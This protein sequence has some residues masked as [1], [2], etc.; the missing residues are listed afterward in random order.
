LKI[1]DCR[2]P[3]EDARDAGASRRHFA[4]GNLP[5]AVCHSFFLVCLLLSP[6][7]HAEETKRPIFTLHTAAGASVTGPI[8][9]IGNDWSITLGGA[10]D[11]EIKGMSL[12]ALRRSKS[13][14]P[15]FPVVEH[16]RLVNGDCLPGGILKIDGE[17]LHFRAQ[18]QSQSF[19]DQGEVL[20]LPLSAVSVLWFATSDGTAD[21]EMLR[22]RLMSERRRKDVVRLRNGDVM[23]GTISA[24]D[25]KM[26]RLETERGGKTGPADTPVERDRLAV[27]ALNTELAHAPKLKGMGARLVL[28]NGCRLTLQSAS[29]EDTRT[30]LGRTP[31]GMAVRI[32]IDQ[33]VSLDVREGQ[34]VYLS[35]LKPSRYEHTSY[36][37]V[38][39]PYVMDGSVAGRDLRLVGSTYDKGIGMHS[40]SRLSFDL[41]GGY[42]RFEALVGLDEKTG[43]QGHVLIQVLVDGKAQDLGVA[44]ELTGMDE[45]RTVQVN[46]T[47]AREVTLVVDFGHGGDVQDH[48]NWVEARLIRER[49]E[50]GR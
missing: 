5:F 10:Q 42:R 8:E 45:P 37:G 40:Q 14:L 16:V 24:L 34:A 29:T 28:S 4:I 17:R 2:L 33:I 9:R 48:V 15:T 46:L 3:I 38:S 11:K 44:N 43:R 30:I 18:F 25:E 47:G 21:A 35:D 36:F 13:L 26:L 20:I 7:L 27:V 50:D 12:I 23:E 22:R 32:P 41:G 49:I 6:S 31:F 39:W 1:A 19:L